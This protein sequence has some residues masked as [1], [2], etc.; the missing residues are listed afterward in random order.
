MKN[1]VLTGFM[2]TGKTT[3]GKKVA[4]TMSFGFI[5]TDRLIEKM[6]NMTVSQIFERHG[7]EFFRR[8]ER[9]AVKK[10]ARLKNFVIATGGGVV[11]NPSNIVQ[12]RK[13][14]VVICFVARPEIILRNIGENK[15]RPLLLSDNP[16]ERI[17]QLLKKREPF[18]KF[19]D[20]TID[21]SDMTI[22]EV[23][24][25]VIKAYIRLKKG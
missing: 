11:L 19:A 7:E 16:E 1:I 10:V 8:L 18:Y 22:D 4:T 23:A 2:A 5:D 25:E 15:D 14:G 24:V 20:S 3:V 6:A 21:V 12:L 17:K 9:A 13:N